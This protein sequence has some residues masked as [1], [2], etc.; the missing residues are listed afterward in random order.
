MPKE[1]VEIACRLLSLLCFVPLGVHLDSAMLL[2]VGVRMAELEAATRPIGSAA[3]FLLGHGTHTMSGTLYMSKD[4]SI[5]Q[6]FV[7]CLLALGDTVPKC[8]VLL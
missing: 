8:Y 4:G 2:E 7:L 5:W 3:R 6:L 1:Q